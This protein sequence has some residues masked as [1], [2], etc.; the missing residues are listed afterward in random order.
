VDVLKKLESN[1]RRLRQVEL[2][3][4]SKKKLSK[5]QVQAL[6]KWRK[7]LR[8]AMDARM[9]RDDTSTDDRRI[10]VD[11]ALD[12][13]V[14]S[15][16]EPGV[17]QRLL[18]ALRPLPSWADVAQRI[19]SDLGHL[20]DCAAKALAHVG[21]GKRGKEEDE[22]LSL[23]IW[24]LADFY[25]EHYGPPTAWWSGWSAGR[26]NRF[27]SLVSAIHRLLPGVTRVKTEKALGE[28]IDET[29]KARRKGQARQSLPR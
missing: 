22:A 19:V 14:L 15:G 16:L 21:S 13:L 20:Q 25:K 23:L 11:C 9:R 3:R 29:L 4:L 24:R 12:Q 28:R 18:L 2:R 1:S 27:V 5:K 10:V 6:E 7:R 8:D 17:F 26:S